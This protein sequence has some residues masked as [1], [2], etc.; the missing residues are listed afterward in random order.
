MVRNK[1]QCVHCD[2]PPPHAIRKEDVSPGITAIDDNVCG[3]MES[4]GN[5]ATSIGK[6]EHILQNGDCGFYRLSRRELFVEPT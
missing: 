5:A 3:N 4:F 2:I 6:V 1:R